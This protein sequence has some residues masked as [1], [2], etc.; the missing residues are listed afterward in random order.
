MGTV[1]NTKKQ[2]ASGAKSLKRKRP[3][4]FIIS[5]L[6]LNDSEGAN[7]KKNLK[8]DLAVAC[9]IFQK[10]FMTDRWNYR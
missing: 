9:S 5:N 4:K 2:L 6:L 8:V 1:S 7:R 3:T 10:D